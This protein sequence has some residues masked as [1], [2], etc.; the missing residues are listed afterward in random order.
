M[1]VW[2]GDSTRV[3]ARRGMIDVTALRPRWDR[4]ITLFQNEKKASIVH[5]GR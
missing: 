3:F 2:G 5:P 1:E 4:N